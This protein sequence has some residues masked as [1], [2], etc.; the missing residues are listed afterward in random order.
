MCL[1]FSTISWAEIELKEKLKAECKTV[2][3]EIYTQ[4]KKVPTIK[5]ISI[6]KTNSGLHQTKIVHYFDNPKDIVTYACV[7]QKN[8]KW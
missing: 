6:Q 1:C 7:H 3:E 8:N 5:N 2:F 4:T